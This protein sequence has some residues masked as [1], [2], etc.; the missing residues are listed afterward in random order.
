MI[1]IYVGMANAA[2]IKEILRSADT[3]RSMHN[4][5]IIRGMYFD[6]QGCYYDTLLGG[7]YYTETDE[8]ADILEKLL[9]NMS[10]A[11]S[12]MQ[13]S[14]DRRREKYLAQY[15]LSM[16]G[17]LLRSAPDTEN[18]EEAS[19][20]LDMAQEFI[21]DNSDNRCY[22]NM[23]SAWYY[24]LAEPDIER[25]K[26]LTTQAEQIARQVFPTDLELIDIIHI[27]TA[28]CFYYHEDFHSAADKIEEA[29]EICR[30]YPDTI[31]YIDK[32][33]ELINILLDIYLAIGD[34]SRC[35]EL[36]A[37]ID[38]LNETYKDQGVSREVSPDIRNQL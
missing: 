6:M 23:V 19:E 9:E 11:I 1:D 25:T 7:A 24:T 31:P 21:E 27:P 18:Y 12:E 15:C 33:A 4:H 10:Y 28:N 26:S 2:Q 30:K 37:E 14:D 38:Q 20:L 17:V 29:V 13:L 3:F 35:R 5:H 32:Q 34:K 36:I 16:A 8:E 22:Y